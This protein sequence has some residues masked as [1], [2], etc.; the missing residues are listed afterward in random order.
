ME[1]LLQA[2]LGERKHEAVIV[3]HVVK[4]IETKH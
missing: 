4:H 3:P 2:D 1:V